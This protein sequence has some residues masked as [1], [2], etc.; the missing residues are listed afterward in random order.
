MADARE[1]PLELSARFHEVFVVFLAFLVVN[2]PT[3]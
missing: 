3:V 1:P 2:Y